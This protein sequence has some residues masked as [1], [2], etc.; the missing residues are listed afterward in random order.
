M[1]G[2]RI[3]SDGVTKREDN[4]NGNL[5]QHGIYSILRIY[6][7]RIESMENSK[8]FTFILKKDKMN[9]KTTIEGSILL[10]SV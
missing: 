3:E 4:S 7:S 5:G 10:G 9:L 1:N 2:R 6:H 8:Q